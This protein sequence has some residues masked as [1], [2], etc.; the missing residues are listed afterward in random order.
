MSDETKQPNVEPK[1]GWW[2]WSDGSVKFALKDANGNVLWQDEDDAQL[3]RVTPRKRFGSHP[4]RHLPNCTGF[5]YTPPPEHIPWAGPGAY[6]MA[7]GEVIVI[8]E[9]IFCHEDQMVVVG[10]DGDPDEYFWNRDGTIDL[11]PGDEQYYLVEKLADWPE[12]PEGEELA[13]PWEYRPTEEDD[14]FLGQHGI[15][16]RA[17]RNSGLNRFWILKPRPKT[18]TVTLTL[19]RWESHLVGWTERWC[20]KQ[21]VEDSIAVKTKTI[22]VPAE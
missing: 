10:G 17:L 7:N 4:V 19:W 12:L 22:E 16:G 6:K 3:H 11:C 13:E 8:D 18:K 1:L 15:A 2:L 21:L 9:S 5:N 14:R 20:E